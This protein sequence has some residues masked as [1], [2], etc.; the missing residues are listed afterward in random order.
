M[1]EGT[2]GSGLVHTSLTLSQASHMTTEDIKCHDRTDN[3]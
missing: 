2:E 3:V 1:Q